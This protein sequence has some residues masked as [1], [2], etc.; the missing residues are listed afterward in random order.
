MGE[1]NVIRQKDGEKLRE[2]SIRVKELKARIV[3]S[4]RRT[5]GADGVAELDRAELD[6]TLA[7]ID[8]AVLRNFIQGLAAPLQDIVSWKQP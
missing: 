4:Q 8:S 1:L 2:D 6:A 3:R 5:A 7:C